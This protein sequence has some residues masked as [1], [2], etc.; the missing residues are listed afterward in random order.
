M[1]LLRSL[2]IKPAGRYR[3]A[4]AL[5]D[6][7]D[8]HG[9]EFSA[10]M[11]QIA[12]AAGLSK[13]QARKHV[14]A[15]IVE[16]LLA[17]A[18]NA[19]GGVPGTGPSY[20]FNWGL[21]EHLAACTPDLFAEARA[22]ITAEPDDAYRLTVNGVQFLACLVGAPGS[23]RVVF[24]RVDGERAK[25][26]DVPLNVLLRDARV[27][28]AWH[29]HLLPNGDADAPFEQMFRLTSQ[30]VEQLATWAQSAAL[31]RVESLVAA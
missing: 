14:H 8:S 29:C 23:R 30:E 1:P 10:T 15:L 17:I 7:H 9:G 26:G 13:V 19:F 3:V 20:I 16:G 27:R 4:L 12:T 11:A 24:W 2:A 25:Y 22:K 5:A 6:L 21:L 28:G 18:G 31:G